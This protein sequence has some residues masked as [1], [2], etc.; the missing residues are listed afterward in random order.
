MC[1]GLFCLLQVQDP[2]LDLLGATLVPVL[3]A[4]V[5]AGASRHIHLVLIGIAAVGADP[6]SHLDFAVY[7]LAGSVVFSTSSAFFSSLF[8]SL[9]DLSHS[10][11]S[12]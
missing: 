10:T 5:A 7:S 9:F 4:D 11:Q 12:A 3:G 8:F 6:P 1:N 2:V